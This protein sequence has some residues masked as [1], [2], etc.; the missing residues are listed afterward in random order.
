MAVKQVQAVKTLRFLGF[1]EALSWLLLLLIAMPLKYLAG[2][3]LMVTYVGWFHGIL[4]MAYIAQLV[5]VKFKYNLGISTVFK[6][7][8]AAFF[9]FGTLVFDK[10]LKH[11]GTSAVQES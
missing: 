8:V 7:F 2:K 4:F 10:T 1:A 9:P 5:I 11:L 3:P 6:G